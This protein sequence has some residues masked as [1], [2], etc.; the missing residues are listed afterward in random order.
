[1]GFLSRQPL[2]AS[3]RH[4]N[5]KNAPREV[6]VDCFPFRRFEGSY[7][8]AVVMVLAK[9]EEDIP[10][11]DNEASPKVYQ[12][13]LFLT[14]DESFEIAKLTI[15]NCSIE[16][17]QNILL[18]NTIHLFNE[19]KGDFI[20]FFE[21]LLIRIDCNKAV[22]PK[23]SEQATECGAKAINNLLSNA[24]AILLAS[25]KMEEI[26]EFVASVAKLKQKSIEELGLAERE[27]KSAKRKRINNIGDACVA[28]CDSSKD[29][30]G[31][32][33]EVADALTNA[34]LKAI[35]KLS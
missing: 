10:N 27:V 8:D 32:S 31:I 35:Q 5:K 15:K 25:L 26:L 23:R 3:D 2:K 28:T 13:S 21:Q 12:Q 22:L 6:K 34:I 11:E 7:K 4:R 17:R 33:S 24:C 9:W 30:S 16:D 29:K 18:E 14:A 19:N 1:M 20:A